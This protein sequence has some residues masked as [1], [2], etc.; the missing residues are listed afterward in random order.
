[1]VELDPLPKTPTEWTDDEC[2][3]SQGLTTNGV[4]HAHLEHTYRINRQECNLT[5]EK[6]SMS[7]QAHNKNFEV[8][9]KKPMIDPTPITGLQLLQ[10]TVAK[11]TETLKK[12]IVQY[13]CTLHLKP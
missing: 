8:K 2:E 6:L 5:L 7:S 1:M 3:S 11:A 4:C 12:F 13:A 10:L 9:K